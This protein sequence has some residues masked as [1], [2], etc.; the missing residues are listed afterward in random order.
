MYRVSLWLIFPLYISEIGIKRITV[1]FFSIR[2]GWKDTLGWKFMKY[3][4]FIINFISNEMIFII[5]L[6]THVIS[7]RKSLGPTVNNKFISLPSNSIQ[8]EK[9]KSDVFEKLGYSTQYNS[10]ENIK[11][12][13]LL[14]CPVEKSHE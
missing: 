14:D 13:F 9:K 6:S 10:V 1:S 11:K 12:K 3:F 5:L 2:F 7:T 4:Y 8:K